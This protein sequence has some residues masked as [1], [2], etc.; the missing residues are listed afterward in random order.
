MKCLKK[1]QL[2]TY[3][4]NE[5]PAEQAAGVKK[6]LETCE[7]CGRAAQALQT[8]VQ[9]LRN[10]LDILEPREVEEKPVGE[11][12]HQI[13]KRKSSRARRLMKPAIRVPVPVMAML[14]V[15]FVAM[16]ALLLHQHQKIADMEKYPFMS[17]NAKTTLYVVNDHRIETRAL[18]IDLEGFQPISKPKVYKEK[19]KETVE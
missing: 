11:I 14:I 19:E 17:A 16:G 2:I 10:R 5:M 6:H 9:L 3:I 13:R 1:S 7:T 12:L 18:D 4:D 8:R 15:M